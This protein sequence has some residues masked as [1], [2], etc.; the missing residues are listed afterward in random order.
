[1]NMLEDASALIKALGAALGM[2]LQLDATGSCGVRF[3]DALDVTLRYESSPPALLVYARTGDL[4]EGSVAEVLRELL[5]DN[6][7]WD[8]TNGATWSLSGDTVVLS[9]L[10]PLEGLEPDPLLAALAIFVEVAL[11]GQRRLASPRGVS[12]TATQAPGMPLSS[13]LIA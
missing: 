6:H 5:E 8:R 10:L 12:A 1:M 11:E 7:V 13:G 9:R 4:P 2:E 3:D